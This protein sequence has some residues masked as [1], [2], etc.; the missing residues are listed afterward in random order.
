MVCFP[1]P[2]MI[3]VGTPRSAPQWGH[4]GAFDSF[5]ERRVVSLICDSRGGPK[6]YRMF[7]EE[8]ISAWFYTELQIRGAP[9]HFIVAVCRSRA[10]APDRARGFVVLPV[11]P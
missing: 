7:T 5:E 4:S 6:L 2:T 3:P 8:S 10:R 9:N 11:A 1:S